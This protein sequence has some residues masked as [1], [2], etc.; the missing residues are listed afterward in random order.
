M[1]KILFYAVGYNNLNR[2]T[3]TRAA[4]IAVSN[5]RNK[6]RSSGEKKDD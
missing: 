5:T 4:E 3:R 1:H 6:K 2:A